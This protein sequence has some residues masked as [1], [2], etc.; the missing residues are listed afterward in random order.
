VLKE[1]T[2]SEVLTD[3]AWAMSYLSDGDDNRIQ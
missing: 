2:D 1:E 3:A